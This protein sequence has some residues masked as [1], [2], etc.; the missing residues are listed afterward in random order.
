M[1]SRPCVSTGLIA[2][3]SI[4]A[5]CVSLVCV[6]PALASSTARTHHARAGRRHIKPRK[7]GELDCNG[8]SLIQRAVRR[9]FNCTDVRGFAHHFTANNW[10]GRF[11]DNGE[12]I[13]HDEPDMTFYSNRPGSGNDVTWAENV[14]LDPFGAPTV[15]DPGHDVVH[16][17]EL[18]PAPWYSMAMCDPNSYPDAPCRP[19]SDSNASTCVGGATTNCSAGGGS[20]FME[21]QLYPPGEPP[22]VDSTSCDDSHWCAA[23]TIDSLEC[24]AGYA[25]CNPDCT[26]PA[27]FAFVQRNGVPA[28]PASPQDSDLATYTPN[29]QTLLINPG[30]RITVHMFDA[31]APGG[32]RAFKVVIDDLTTGQSGSMQASAANGF[33]T[34]SPADCSGTPFNFQP[35]YNTASPDND[36]SWA[37]LQTNISTEYETGHFE[38]C[39]SVSDPAGFPLFNSGLTDTYWNVCNGPYEANDADESTE[40]S[41]AF[42][43]PKGDTHGALN[44]PPDEVTGCEDNLEQNGDLDFDGTPF[45]RIGPSGR[46]R[47]RRSQAAS[48]NSCRHPTAAATRRTR[49]RPMS[50]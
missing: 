43:Y 10:S 16:W 40:P 33:A 27:N 15:R 41:D 12:Y 47:P 48:S 17:F 22:F 11:F 7:L 6:A 35:E 37:A 34:T 45:T 9:S 23:L 46:S 4:A 13:G 8:Q 2:R 26:E 20:A 1:H 24:T 44:T 25:T 49:C 19:E 30:D 36:V 39:S 50:R 38:P 5:V 18:S 3:L 29:G 32:G 21:M 31:P 42:C 28:G 14:P